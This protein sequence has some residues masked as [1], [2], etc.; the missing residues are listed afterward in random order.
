MRFLALTWDGGGNLPPLLGV[1]EALAARG[2]MIEVLGHETQRA[3]IE[4]SGAT[5]LGFDAADQRDAARPTVNM[6]EW[7][8]AFDSAARDELI[9]LADARKPDILIVDAMLPAALAGANASPWPTIA[10][11]HAPYQM[12]LDYLD[13]RFRVPMETAD[14]ALVL[15]YEAFHVGAAVP[16]NVLFAGPARPKTTTEWL[17]A[18]P[19]RKLILA[20]LSTVQQNQESVLR[21]LCAALSTIDADVL[22]TTGRALAPESFPAGPNMTLVRDAPHEAVLPFSDLLIT[23]GGHGTVM[24]GL[25]AGVPILCLPGLGDQ[26]GN[27]RRVAELGLGEIIA[28]DSSPETLRAVIV[29]LLADERLQSR[30]RSFAEDV[31]NFAGLDTAVLRVEALNT[32]RT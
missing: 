16:A 32:R 26:P 13:G 18:Q 9:A 28:T 22:V 15:S 30:C 17:P 1:V 29:R 31:A 6:I 19:E 8:T 10:L 24:A 7:L 5:F 4:A 11:I 21:N 2:H 25:H 14:L 27:A 20:S 23:H 12:L 3:A